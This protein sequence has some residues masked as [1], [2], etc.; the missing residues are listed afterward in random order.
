MGGIPCVRA[1]ETIDDVILRRERSE[2]RRMDARYTRGHPSRRARA[3]TSGYVINFFRRLFAGAT[4]ERNSPSQ[5]IVVDF[6]PRAWYPEIET[7]ELRA[8]P[9]SLRD[10][11]F[12]AGSRAQ[13]RP[14]SSWPGLA[15]PFRPN[16]HNP[17]DS[18]ACLSEMAGTSGRLRP[19]SRAKSGHD[20]LVISPPMPMACVADIAPR[21]RQ[22][23]PFV[24]LT[25][26]YNGKRVVASDFGPE[27]CNFGGAGAIGYSHQGRWKMPFL[28]CI[29]QN[30]LTHQAA[31]PCTGV[32]AM[33]PH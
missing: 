2:P 17:S 12:V 26:L 22:G 27:P 30:V 5:Q 9:G 33:Q 23:R 25:V 29:L 18:F 19:S 32:M 4:A 1:R 14:P 11:F 16:W 10:R 7:D 13:G 8:D 24:D 21:A 28:S 3:R 31:R 15:R 20:T 6:C